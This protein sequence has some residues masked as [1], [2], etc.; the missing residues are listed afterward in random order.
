MEMR[1]SLSSSVRYGR[2]ISGSVGSLL[3]ENNIKKTLLVYDKGIFKAGLTAPIRSAIEK[4]GIEVAVFDNVEPNP[5]DISISEGAAVARNENVQAIV[6]IGGGSAMDC[7]KGINVLQANPEPIIQYEGG[8]NVPNRGLFMVCIPTTAGTSSE[9]TSVCIITDT[10]TERKYIMAGKN[11][12]A[13]YAL[14]DPALT[15]NLPQKVSAAT[16]VD[17]LTHALE[18]Y[19]SLGANPLTKPLSLQAAKLIYNNLAE[20][21]NV[22]GSKNARDQMSLGCIIVGCAFSNAGL[23]LVHAI[24]HTLS[25]HFGLAHGVA[26][27]VTLPYVLEYNYESAKEGY[28][29][30]KEAICP[31]TEKSLAQLVLELERE[32]DMPRLGQC[33]VPE[34]KLPFLAAET[35]KEDYMTNPNTVINEEV[36]LEI[37]KKAY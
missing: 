7:A 18:S 4:E 9:I 17:A 26:C 16:G 20:A 31:G 25:A 21:A 30:L 22:P 33:G 28:D 27:G 37:L 11:V 12:G 34:D 36:V 14:V 35:M 8:D 15:D 1:F 10:Q 29:E 19:V 32:L 23:G 13:D 3:R 2:G 24:S 6:A 5:T